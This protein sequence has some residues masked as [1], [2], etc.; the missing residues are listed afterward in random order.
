MQH[1]HCLDPAIKLQQLE[2]VVEEI[3]PGLKKQLIISTVPMTIG[4]AIISW[5]S[6]PSSFTLFN[7]G[8]QKTVKDL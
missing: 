4:I 6:L 1:V 2:S 5:I 3:E 7:F 8:V